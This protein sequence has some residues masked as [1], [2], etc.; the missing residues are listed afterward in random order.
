MW[1]AAV[2]DVL[3]CAVYDCTGFGTK[4][5]R[6]VHMDGIEAAS[7][8]LNFDH[9]GTIRGGRIQSASA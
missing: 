3:V 1:H 6:N 7:A 9:G 2:W 8:E 4:Y 5:N